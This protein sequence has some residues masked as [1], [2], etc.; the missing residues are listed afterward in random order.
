M[1]LTKKEI[2]I[3]LLLAT[4]SDGNTTWQ[5]PARTR[6]LDV[7]QKILVWAKDNLITDE[8]KNILLL[9][10]D[11]EGNTSWQCAAKWVNLELLQKILDW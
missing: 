3:H 1:N 2:D 7:F 5:I 10:T 6:N 9:A 11:R 4:D 8:I